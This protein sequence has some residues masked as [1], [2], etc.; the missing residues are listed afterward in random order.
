MQSTIHEPNDQHMSS[1]IE[2]GSY[3][4]EKDHQMALNINKAKV[5]QTARYEGAAND[6]RAQAV[7]SVG[8]RNRHNSSLNASLP[9]DGSPSLRFNAHNGSV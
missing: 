5:N 1:L 9:T 7:I 3:I 6:F 8:S 2:G 4:Y